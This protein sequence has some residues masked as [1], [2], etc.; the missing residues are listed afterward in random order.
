MKIRQTIYIDDKVA[1]SIKIDAIKE[2]KTIG[3]FIENVYKERKKE[4][5]F[6]HILFFF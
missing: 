3:E 5:M 2:E 4:G 6:P 1:K